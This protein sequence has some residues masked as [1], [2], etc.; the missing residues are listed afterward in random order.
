MSNTRFQ[1]Y[2]CWYFSHSSLSLSIRS[3]KFLK[4]TYPEISDF[5]LKVLSFQEYIAWLEISVNYIARVNQ[6]QTQQYLH[7]EFLNF[8]LSEWQ[9]LLKLN[10]LRYIS[11]VAVF[12]KDA[13]LLILNEATVAADDI[14]VVF[15]LHH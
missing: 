3:V 4:K 8:A 1:Y 10:V 14:L 6:I 2:N 12:L 9:T 11:S 13:D 7:N 5:D 15:D